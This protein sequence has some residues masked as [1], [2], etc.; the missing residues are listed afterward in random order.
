MAATNGAV[1]R[2]V[3]A[4]DYTDF[5]HTGPGTL[6]GRYLRRFWQPVYLATDLPA[7]HAKPIRIMSEDFTLYRGEGGHPHV[8]APRCAHRGTQ[9][10]TGWVEG[11][12]I[13]CFY[14]GWKYDHTGQ[15]VE[16][17]AE[18]PSFPPKVRIASYPTEEYLGL[19]FAY[20]GEGAPPPLA[21]WPELE[22]EG[23]LEQSTYLRPCNYFNNLENMADETHIAFAHRRSVFDRVGVNDDLPRIAAEETEYGIRRMGTR[24]N[25]ITR[26][27]HILMP[28]GFYFKGTPNDDAS[29]WSEMLAW[30]V[31][32]DD[33]QHRS[34]NTNLVH[35]TGEAAARYRERQ[36]ARRA[37][38]AALPPAEE[39]AAAVL[40][41]ELRPQDIPERDD[42]IPIQDAIAQAGQGV[43]ADRAHERLGREDS[44]IILL[45]KLWARELQALAEGRPLKAWQRT[46]RL[47]AAG[48]V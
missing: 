21:R 36:A 9:L 42:L 31:P 47:T 35:V 25:G 48:G 43:I 41:G 33:T 15:C 19:I 38:L 4:A 2:E 27:S 39:V 34:F 46:E 6:A 20:L 5:V 44:V 11:D 1:R 16:M 14:H 29:G 7:G 13:R 40:R 8:I 45:R 37:A 23:V 10:S 12:C 24:A 17:P 18:D 3:A 26:V 22:G 30:R 32:I 28:N